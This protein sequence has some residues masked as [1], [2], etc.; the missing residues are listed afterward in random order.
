MRCLL[1]DLRR[2]SFQLRHQ[3]LQ[4]VGILLPRHQHGILGRYDDE[5]VDAFQRHQRLVR[6]DVAVAGIL[7]HGGALRGVALA[8]LFRQFPHRMPGADIGPAAGHRHHGGARRLLH[9]R[10]VDRDRLCRA[11][12]LGVE[13]DEAEIAPGPGDGVGHRLD[14]GGIELAVFVEQQRR[15]EHEV[16]AVPEIAAL[17][18]VGGRRL[19]RLLD[20]FRDRAHFA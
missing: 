17:D 19:I 11:E 16:A 18:V 3:P 7:E 15:A 10:I 1:G 14:A 8:V 13:R 2:Y 12:G 4:A 9:H 6:R 20:E 5:I